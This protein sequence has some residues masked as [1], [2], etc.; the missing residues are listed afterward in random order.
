MDPDDADSTSYSI[1]VAPLDDSIVADSPRCGDDEPHDM[2]GAE[3]PT[4]LDPISLDGPDL[5]PDLTLDAPESLSPLSTSSYHITTMSPNESIA[6]HSR[7]S[8]QL[9]QALEVLLAQLSV[10]SLGP[11][12]LWR[13]G[14]LKLSQH[15]YFVCI[16]VSYSENDPPVAMVPWQSLDALLN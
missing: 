9:Q 10:T 11:V 5:T 1:A 4:L 8:F 15:L 2:D 12:V 7:V 6:G 3:K 13:W 16:Q 14:H